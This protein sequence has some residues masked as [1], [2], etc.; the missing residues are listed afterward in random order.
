VSLDLHWR[1]WAGNHE[2][3]LSSIATPS[4]VDE[5][6]DLICRTADRGGH[7]R[8]AG[9]GHS[10]TPL[11]QTS[12]TLVDLSALTNSEVVVDVQRGRA[13]IPAGMRLHDIGPAL[14]KDGVAIANQGDV[15]VQTLAGALST[16]TKGSGV[17]H[18]TMSS[19]LTAATLID[20]TG[21]VVRTDGDAE[22]LRGVQVSLGLLGVLVEVELSVVPRYVLREQNAVMSVAQLETDWEQLKSGFHHFSFWWMPTATSSMIYGLPE[23]PADHAYVKMLTAEPA[24]GDAELRG[25]V[26]SRVGPAHLVYPDTEIGDAFFELEYVVDA[27]QDLAAFLQMRDF[28]QHE[29]PDETTPLQVRWQAADEAY[30]SPQYR[31]DSVSLSVSGMQGTHYEPFLRAVDG[32]LQQRDARPHWGKIHFLDGA[33]VERL[34][35]ALGTFRAVRRRLDPHGVFLNDHLRDLITPGVSEE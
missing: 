14:W 8:V 26:G 28:M 1:N 32:L 31:R 9:S 12:D 6:A 16:G 20:G 4:S 19:R 13:R 25:E 21:E 30:L 23:V 2:F 24:E 29:H 10:F 3:T 22:L 17:K 35:P 11:V 34:Y 33:R 27:A 15:D 18:G 5:L 7:L